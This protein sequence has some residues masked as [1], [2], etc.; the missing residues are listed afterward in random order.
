MK[1]F[2]IFIFILSLY[3]ICPLVSAQDHN[4][5]VNAKSLNT[6]EHTIE[7]GQTVYAIAT[8]YGVTPEDIYRLNPGSA[9]GIKAG[10]ILLIPQR[11]LA[12]VSSTQSQSPSDNAY[13]FHTIQPKETLYSLS[14]KYAIPGSAIIEANPGL[15][16][17]TFHIGRTIR[18][19]ASTPEMLPQKITKEVVKYLDYTVG[20]KETVYHICRKFKI[21]QTDLLA[22]NP[23]LRNGMRAG[24]KLQIPQLTE[25]TVTEIKNQ[26]AEKEINAMLSRPKDIKHVKMTKVALLLPF[27]TNEAVQSSSTARFVE[28]YEGLLL[29]ID[30]LRN[31]GNSIQLDV[32]DT[33]NGTKQLANILKE[34]ALK[35]A[36]LI[37]GAVQNDQITP[38]AKFAEKNNIKYVIPFTSKNDDVLSNAFI[39]QVNTP[40]SYLYAKAAEAGCDLF[41][42]DNIIILNVTA[43][44][45][46]RDF[47]KTFRTEM[48]ARHIV[49]KEL[50]YNA[51][52]FQAELEPLLSPDKNNVIVPTS[53][54]LEA[55]N[56]ICSPLRMI[57]ESLPEDQIS[58]FGYPEWQTYAKEHLD[59]FYA[60]NTY[61]YTNFY[62][63]NLSTD[64][65]DFYTKYKTWYSKNLINTFPKYGIL[66]FDTGMYFLGATSKYGSNFENHLDKIKYKSLQTGFNFQRVNNWGG[67]INTNIFIV[68]YQKNF[69]VTRNEVK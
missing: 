45:E 33:G 14:I 47:I 42:N 65:S 59:D 50:K 44:D 8:M 40:H 2:G 32:Y 36:N 41:K 16:T 26:P 7:S 5:S 48:A 1:N 35:E 21:S 19:P 18:I 4:V 30:S 29:A 23:D 62:A 34:P 46:K 28:Y 51:E 63:D 11:T 12:P 43:P 49:W 69:K 61:I 64:V 13:Q 67:F 24:M 52:T 60:L 25:E 55:L 3:A 58:M 66:G 10:A 27:M 54:S 38:V 39:Y 53:S 37:I 15:S 9:D 56:K 22:A 31:M 6:F 17:S 20:K 57:Q 68:H